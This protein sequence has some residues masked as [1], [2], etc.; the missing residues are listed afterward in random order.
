MLQDESLV[1]HTQFEFQD[2]EYLIQISRARTRSIYGEENCEVRVEMFAIPKALNKK[3]ILPLS[4]STRMFC[5][6]L[7]CSQV[8]RPSGTPEQLG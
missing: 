2:C 7:A 5:D 8:G 4:S 1:K 3:C 6:V